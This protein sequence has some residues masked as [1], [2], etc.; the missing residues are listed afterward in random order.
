MGLVAGQ[1]L[2]GVAI[3]WEWILTDVVLFHSHVCFCSCRHRQP[4]AA[5]MLGIEAPLHVFRSLPR[6]LCGTLPAWSC[7]GWQWR[8]AWQGRHRRQ[9]CLTQGPTSIKRLSIET[10]QTTAAGTDRR[11]CCVP[12]K[13]G[14]GFVFATLAMPTP[15]PAQY[16]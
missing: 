4:G 9:T 6:W 13:G 16:E 1:V 7:Q 5:G 12:G 11:N 8:Q 10:E 2:V 15:V 14:G 3:V